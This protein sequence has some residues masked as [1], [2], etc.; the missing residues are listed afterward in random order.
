MSEAC[1]LQRPPTVQDLQRLYYELAKRGAPAWA[2]SAPWPYRLKND[3]HLLAL[4]ADM[5]R[6]D[7]RLLTLLVHWLSKSWGTLH[8][9]RLRGWM[10]RMRCVQSLL[11]VIDF[12]RLVD[13]EAELRFAL[14]YL[15]AGWSR[16]APAQRFFLDAERPGSRD[17]VRRL[18][19]NL[20]PYAR[21]GL[22]GTERPTVDA[23]TKGT[24]G[25]YDA[26][27]RRQILDELLARQPSLRLPDYLA[28][29][30]HSVSRQQARADLRQHPRLQPVGHGRGARWELR[31][32]AS[33]F[34]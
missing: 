16:L 25:G 2:Q 33:S 21:W 28:A 6:Y 23:A 19:R 22:I 3:E 29:I 30:D 14:D 12:V 24:V 8:L 1:V 5:L 20:K 7:A 10:R 31:A 18:G 11:V 13:D 17:A 26:V 27:T 32:I 4:A 9:I 15:C 34:L